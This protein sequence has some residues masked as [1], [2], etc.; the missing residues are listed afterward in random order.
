MAGLDAG[1]SPVAS[2][3]RTDSNDLV[4]FDIPS[5]PLAGA[6]VTFSATTG[7]VVYYDG[8]LAVGRRSAALK[9]HFTPTLGLQVLLGGTGY[10]PRV[11]G[12]DMYTLAPAPQSAA[13]TGRVSDALIQRYEAYF[14]ALQTRISTA[15]CGIDTDRSDALLIGI[16]VTP[17]GVI[18]RARILGAGSDPTQ[19]AAVAAIL[20]GLSIGKPPPAGLP[21][22]VTMAIYP[23]RA[24]DARGCVPPA[25]RRTDN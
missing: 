19:D 21:Q 9:G 17:S 14:A 7:L 3:H 11:T 20:R 2:V 12:P 4:A 8:A 5:Q 1:A 15:V 13:S 25:D 22:P 23:P 16:W 6:L 24:N 18:A 10:A